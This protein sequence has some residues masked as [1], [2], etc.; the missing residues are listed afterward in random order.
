MGFKL[1]GAATTGVSRFKIYL[2]WCYGIVPFISTLMSLSSS[3]LCAFT[4]NPLNQ[5]D[6][7]HSRRR[8]YASSLSTVTIFCHTF[9]GIDFVDDGSTTDSNRKINSFSFYHQTLQGGSAVYQVSSDVLISRWKADDNN[10]LF[11]YIYV[12]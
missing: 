6:Y 7:L 5:R 10:N 4:Q 9:P 12:T 8:T 1:S 3:I 2:L 11:F